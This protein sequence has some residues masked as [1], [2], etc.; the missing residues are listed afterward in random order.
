VVFVG[1]S[2]NQGPR[3][4]KDRSQRCKSTDFVASLKKRIQG[5]VTVPGK[6]GRQFL[7]KEMRQ[8]Q[9]R[10]P[11]Y[12]R[13]AWEYGRQHWGKEGNMVGGGQRVERSEIE[14]TILRAQKSVRAGI[15]Y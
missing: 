12:E 2:K 1:K 7:Q 11:A 3:L 5:N 9:V 10:R 4:I 14:A 6:K 15:V 13:H 8:K